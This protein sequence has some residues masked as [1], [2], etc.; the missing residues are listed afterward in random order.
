M[1][2]IYEGNLFP[3]FPE[4]TTKSGNKKSTVAKLKEENQ[5]L[6]EQSKAQ[7]AEIER[8]K[9][10]N[11]VLLPKAEAFDDLMASHS[12]FPLGVIAKNFGRTAIW[13]NQYLADKHVQYKRGD[14]WMLYSK[15]DQCGYTRVCWYN[16]SEDT[17]GR[18]LSR[19]HTYWTGKGMAFIRSLLIADGLLT[20]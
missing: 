18:V 4:A 8:L 14:V 2:K 11:S 13:L 20:E 15:Y 16:Y 3:E 17:K 12:L 1:E 10:E 9:K 19:A 7:K 6:K 5:K